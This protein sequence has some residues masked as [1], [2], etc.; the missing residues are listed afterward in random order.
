LEKE[1]EAAG[2]G[3]GANEGARREGGGRCRCRAS[4]QKEADRSASSGK[5]R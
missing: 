1:E 2:G 4:P 3:R 5:Q